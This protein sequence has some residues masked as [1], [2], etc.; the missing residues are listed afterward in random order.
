MCVRVRVRVRVCVCVC[1]CVCKLSV[2][3]KC[4]CLTLYRLHIFE[5]VPD[6]VSLFVLSASLCNVARFHHLIVPNLVFF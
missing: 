6:D 1:V 2:K 3:V 4:T 5:S